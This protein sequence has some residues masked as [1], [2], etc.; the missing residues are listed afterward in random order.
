MRDFAV[1]WD[2]NGTI[3]DDAQLF[4][5]IMNLFLKEQHLPLID[6]DI[7]RESFEFPIINYYRRLGFDFK[8]ESFES[9]GSRFIDIYQEKRFNAPLFPG[10]VDIIKTLNRAGVLQFVVSAQENSLLASSVEYYR[11]HYY[12]CD[13][14]GVDNVFADGKVELAINLKNKYLSGVKNVFVVGDS[15]QDLSVA[16]SLSA[17]PLLVSYGHYAKHRLVGNNKAILI[18]CVS[19]LKTFFL[20]KIK[21][22][23]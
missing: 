2:W 8:K 20:K 21:A 3:V 12:F 16:R 10:I 19:A 6:V 11:L 5:D 7:Y 9:L 15:L 14:R 23:N 13:F 4:V 18:D 22:V 1:V 17:T